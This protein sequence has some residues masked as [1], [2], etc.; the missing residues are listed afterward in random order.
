MD[1]N[2]AEAVSNFGSK[3]SYNK[4]LAQLLGAQ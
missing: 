1:G 2:Y 4:A 3:S